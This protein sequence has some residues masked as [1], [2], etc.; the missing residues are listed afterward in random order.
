MANS[1]N[2]IRA[3]LTPKLKDIPN[4]VN[5]LTYKTAKVDQHMI[6]PELFQF[7]YTTIYNPP[8]PDFTVLGVDIPQNDRSTH[9]ALSG[10][11]ISIVTWGSGSVSWDE[12]YPVQLLA[13]SVVFIGANTK[14]SF[15]SKDQGMTLYRAFMAVSL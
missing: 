8:I 13:G 4:L 12:G 5:G 7:T 14:V 2:V 6:K 15:T 10:P 11:S 3:G 1:D 9:E